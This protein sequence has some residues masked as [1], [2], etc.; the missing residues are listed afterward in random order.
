MFSCIC[1]YLHRNLLK[2]SINSTFCWKFWRSKKYNL[3]L[4][5]SHYFLKLLCEALSIKNWM[6]KETKKKKLKNFSF[7]ENKTKRKQIWKTT[8][9]KK[10]GKNLFFPFTFK[11]KTN[12]FSVL[13]LDF[14]V[15]DWTK[16]KFNEETFKQTLKV[17]QTSTS[18]WIYCRKFPTKKLKK[19]QAT[20]FWQASSYF[21][22]KCHSTHT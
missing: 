7:F 17:T 2:F 8:S 14:H 6:L 15:K 1:L 4:L 22:L 13:L 3:F 5:V 10:K 12:M 19:S 18:V 21:T 9:K 11:N 20:L 16:T